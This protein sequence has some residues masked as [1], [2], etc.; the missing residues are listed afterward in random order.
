[1]NDLQE[2]IEKDQGRKKLKSPNTEEIRLHLLLPEKVHHLLHLGAQLH[3][4]VVVG[5][6]IE[7]K[8]KNLQKVLQCQRKIVIFFLIN[9]IT[10]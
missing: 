9:L 4:A 1:M 6:V 7:I 3:R 8:Q 10:H 5:A 2:G